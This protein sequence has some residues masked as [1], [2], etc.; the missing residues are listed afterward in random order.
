MTPWAL[1]K[2]PSIP[3]GVWFVR[4]MNRDDGTAN[5]APAR[6]GQLNAGG[7]EVHP[8]DL[9]FEGSGF[10]GGRIATPKSKPKNENRR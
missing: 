5:L 9:L 3:V 6:R 1:T 4:S 7:S 10:T 8:D 2:T